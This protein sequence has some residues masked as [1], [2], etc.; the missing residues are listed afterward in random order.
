MKRVFFII[1]V[2]AYCMLFA[3][4][5]GVVEV[6]ENLKWNNKCPR[7]EVPSVR[8]TDS[9]LVVSCDSVEAMTVVVTTSNGDQVINQC[10]I[11][12]PAELA[13]PLPNNFYPCGATVELYCE[14]R[15]YEGVF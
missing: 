6:S 15:K 8:Y 5:E 13:I 12:S 14:E 1:C 2:M 4:A 9:T 7:S 3:K 11:A 10:I